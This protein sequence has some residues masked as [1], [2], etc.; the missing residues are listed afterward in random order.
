MS[1]VPVHH[2]ALHA[3]FVCL[4]YVASSIRNV[5]RTNLTHPPPC[6]E[7][8]MRKM[9][10]CIV[11]TLRVVVTRILRSLG[12]GVVL[13]HAAC[14]YY[15]DGA[16]MCGVCRMPTLPAHAHHQHTSLQKIPSAPLIPS[17]TDHPALSWPP[18]SPTSKACVDGLHGDCADIRLPVERCGG[19][20]GIQGIVALILSPFPDTTWHPTPLLDHLGRCFH[21][22][23]G[24]DIRGG[25]AVRK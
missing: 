25:F 22:D 14:R 7:S 15:V 12:P 5:V 17:R 2:T 9:S 6:P 19:S 18:R 13:S 3:C 21:R 20:K 4:V 1:Q 16:S 10:R 23:G 24:A 11:R 8:L